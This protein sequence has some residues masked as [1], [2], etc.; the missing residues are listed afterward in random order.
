MQGEIIMNNELVELLAEYEHKRWTKWQ[1]Y[2][3]SKSLKNDDGSVTI[4]KELVDRWNRQILTDYNDLTESEKE[5]DRN[6]AKE[7]IK[8]L[9]IGDKNGYI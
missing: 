6:G 3:F 5:S 9:K 7:I 1:S 2:L 8:I 4:P